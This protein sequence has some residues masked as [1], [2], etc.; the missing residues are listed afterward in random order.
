[1]L[2]YK[3]IESKETLGDGSTQ[4]IKKSAINDK[5]ATVLNEARN[6][7]TQAMIS[8]LNGQPSDQREMQ[9]QLHIIAN[10]VP[11]E[12]LSKKRGILIGDEFIDTYDKEYDEVTL[13]RL[14]FDGLNSQLT[15]AKNHLTDYD[16][17]TTGQETET[18]E[19]AGQTGQI[20]YS[21]YEIPT[22]Q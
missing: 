14:F 15:R 2:K 12:F 13:R 19:E 20:D 6:Y 22:R 16:Y 8:D 10:L 9:R 4:I 17:S 11:L 7:I 21:Q 3:M 18:D 5:D 1:M